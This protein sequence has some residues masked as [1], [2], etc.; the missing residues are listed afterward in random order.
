MLSAQPA[1]PAVDCQ[2]TIPNDKCGK[3]LPPCARLCIRAGRA[4][5]KVLDAP[6]VTKDS[7]PGATFESWSTLG[8]I[9]YG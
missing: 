5:Y 9:D 3:V 2:L 7:P 6:E 1:N 4:R 8:A